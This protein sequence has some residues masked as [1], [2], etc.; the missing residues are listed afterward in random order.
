MTSKGSYNLRL[1]NRKRAKRTDPYVEEMASQIGVP[2]AQTN[3]NRDRV[4]VEVSSKDTQSNLQSLLRVKKRKEES[5]EWNPSLEEICMKKD[6]LEDRVGNM[7]TKMGKVINS[8][9]LLTQHIVGNK[10]QNSKYESP[11]YLIPAVGNGCTPIDRSPKDNI[12]RLWTNFGKEIMIILTKTIK[13]Q[14][15]CLKEIF[16]P[17]K[18]MYLT[19]EEAEVASYI[20]CKDLVTEYDQKEVLVATNI[21]YCDGQR[22]LRIA[23]D[24]AMNPVNILQEMVKKRVEDWMKTI[25]RDWGEN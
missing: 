15:V 24:L 20:F 12:E 21:K 5:G 22:R 13:Q 2:D 14:R 4:I 8:I 3:N 7:E 16:K 6:P 10:S 25:T 11:K 18:P 19:K 9:H 23:L 1:S 17:S